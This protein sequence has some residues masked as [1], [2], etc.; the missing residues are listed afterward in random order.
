MPSLNDTLLYSNIKEA[1]LFLFHLLFTF[2][3]VYIIQSL[4][5]SREEELARTPGVLDVDE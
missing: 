1:R 4:Y 2:I 5:L 3:T